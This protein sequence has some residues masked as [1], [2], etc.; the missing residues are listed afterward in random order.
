MQLAYSILIP[1]L[2]GLGLF[3]IIYKKTP[4][5]LALA[6][7]YPIGIGIITF[8]MFFL[9]IMKIP[10]NLFSISIAA[11]LF[12][13]IFITILYKSRPEASF[14]LDSTSL[15]QLALLLLIFL[16]FFYVLL[17]AMIKPVFT[18][19]AW[20]R[21]A[22]VSKAI[23]IDQSFLTDY[24]IKRIE[25]YPLLI[26]LNQTWIL[27]CQGYWNDIS[28]KII[29]PLL[30]LS[31][32]AIFYF[33]LRK[34]LKKTTALFFTLLLSTLPFLVFHSTTSYLDLP[35]TFFYSAGTI[36]L[37]VYLKNNNEKDLILSAILLG[38]GVWTKRAGIYLTG[39]DTLVLIGY[40][41]FKYKDKTMEYLGP[42]FKYLFIL[43]GMTLPW[44]IYNKLVVS[45]HYYTMES[46]IIINPDFLSRL[47][48]VITLFTSKMFHSANWHL[49]WAIFIIV[50]IFWFRKIK[51][52][53]IALLTIILINLL[54][55]IY[56]F[57]FSG[58][59]QY[60]LDGTVFNRVMMYMIPV[61]L[62]FCGLMF[63][64]E[65]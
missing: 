14:K 21:Y 52:E 35:M 9:G 23:F 55:L 40:L 57:I 31:L 25:D 32:L 48:N 37:Y 13:T 24:V 7:S 65:T 5:Y 18:W 44:I 62:F 33:G 27:I 43:I 26:T 29:S 17:E 36:F 63:S 41:A 64:N 39:I 28:I 45:A 51:K 19:D 47:P 20:S 10:L 60:L 22:V 4:L 8:I 56:T 58:S 2:L 34:L 50:L 15:L 59:Y 38:L 46:L 16:K 42:F 6:V 3:L 61:V 54:V 1:F 53:K 30:F 12:I 49:T 11:W